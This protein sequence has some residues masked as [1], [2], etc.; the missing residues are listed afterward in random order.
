ME[1][2]IKVQDYICLYN[3][4]R[5]KMLRH[6]V[7]VY[8]GAEKIV[9]NKERSTE[10]SGRSVRDCLVTRTWA[11][12]PPWC[13]SVCWWFLALPLIEQWT[14]FPS[15][16]VQCPWFTPRLY[17]LLWQCSEW[18]NATFP[19]SPGWEVEPSVSANG[20]CACHFLVTSNRCLWDGF[21]GRELKSELRFNLEDYR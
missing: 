17:H 7:L 3:K 4:P 9:V 13:R 20:A 8:Y 21:V 12:C 6:F 10:S 19:F 2:R 14:L 11:L 15:V 5:L 16:T 1:E 18:N